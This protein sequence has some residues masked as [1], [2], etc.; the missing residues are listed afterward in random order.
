MK[1][2]LRYLLRPKTYDRQTRPQCQRTRHDAD[3]AQNAAINVYRFSEALKVIGPEAVPS[4]VTYAAIIDLRDWLFAE[5]AQVFHTLSTKRVPLSASSE[6]IARD[7]IR[8]LEYC[9]LALQR[10]DVIEESLD[11][12]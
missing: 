5:R 12:D 4:F 8:L 10:I 7:R 3:A 1:S 11:L 6:A 2:V 9:H